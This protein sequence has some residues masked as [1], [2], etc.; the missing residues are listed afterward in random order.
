MTVSRY[1]TITPD[2]ASEGQTLTICVSGTPTGVAEVKL[3]NGSTLD[4]EEATVVVDIGGA[5]GPP[6]PTGCILWTVPE[7]WGDFVVASCPHAND[8]S[9]VVD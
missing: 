5:G 2:P 6:P 3:T 9:V 8:V 7:G 4:P 1:I